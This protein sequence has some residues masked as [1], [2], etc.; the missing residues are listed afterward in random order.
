MRPSELFVVT[1]HCVQAACVWKRGRR[2][3]ITH[4]S[5]QYP[6]FVMTVPVHVTSLQLVT[7]FALFRV[8][9]QDTRYISY[10]RFYSIF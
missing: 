8:F 6:L 1:F 5:A 7:S 10:L 9:G 4:L 3:D 2:Y